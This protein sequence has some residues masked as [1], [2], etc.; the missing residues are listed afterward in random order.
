MSKILFLADLNPNKFGSMEEMILF[1]GM[2]LKRRGDELVLGVL[3]YPALEVAELFTAAGIKV[4]TLESSPG[5]KEKLSTFQRIQFIRRLIREQSIDLVHINFYGMMNSIVLG[6]Y[7]TSAKVLFTEHTSGVPPVRGALKYFLS[8]SLHFFISKRV[9]KYIAVSNFVGE[10]LRISHHVD[11]DKVVTIY[12][13]VNVERFKPLDSA[14]SRVATGLPL[15][16]KIILSVAML[17]PEKGLHYLIDAA[18]ILVKDFGMK[19]LCVVIVGEGDSRGELERQVRENQLSDH[20]MFLGRRSD[21]NLLVAAA[22]V[23]AVPAVWAESF[24]L[25]IAEAM[26]GGRPVVASRI[27]GIPELVEDGITGLLVDPGDRIGLAMAI[28]SVLPNSFFREMLIKNARC[29]VNEKFSLSPQVAKVAELYRHAL[30][31]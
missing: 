31:R 5:V 12:N 26:A 7:L 30:I 25:I 2:E 3:S 8:K 4:V 10:R 11:P 1:L 21:V 24:G 17:I 9:T 20:V 28:K 13:G 6:A 27:G 22:D 15:D 19:D 23:V 16:R 29:K 18:A 14:S